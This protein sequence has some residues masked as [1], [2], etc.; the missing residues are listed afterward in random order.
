M[1][2]G[3]YDYDYKEIQEKGAERNVISSDISE[4]PDYEDTQRIL[5]DFGFGI[6]AEKTTES[7]EELQER[8]ADGQS[9]KVEN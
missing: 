5:A 3:Y 8:V 6:F 1:D 9:G 4:I 7:I 2:K